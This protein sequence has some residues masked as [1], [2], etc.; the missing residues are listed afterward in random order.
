MKNLWEDQ[1]LV[2]EDFNIFLSREVT[3]HGFPELFF[4]QLQLCADLVVLRDVALA[5]RP[6]GAS[7][8]SALIPKPR[9]AVSGFPRF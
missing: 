6:L 7:Y 4:V 5:V 9:V 2:S 1:A 3:P 8:N